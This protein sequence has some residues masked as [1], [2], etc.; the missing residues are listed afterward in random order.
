MITGKT[1]SQLDENTINALR[2]ALSISPDT[3]FKGLALT[4]TF[5]NTTEACYY[6]ANGPGTY[7]NF[8]G[9]TITGNYAF[10][11]WNGTTWSKYDTTIAFDLTDNDT[12]HAIIAKAIYED[13]LFNSIEDGRYF[14]NNDAVIDQATVVSSD[15]VQFK[16]AVR[17]TGADSNSRVPIMYA[18]FDKTSNNKGNYACAYLTPTESTSNMYYMQ[19]RFGYEFKPVS[20][21]QITD[22]DLF[23]VAI[24]KRTLSFDA[25]NVATITGANYI[26]K[27][28]K[29]VKINNIN[30][31]KVGIKYTGD[32]PSVSSFAYYVGFGFS[33]VKD[34]LQGYVSGLHFEQ[35]FVSITLSKQLVPFRQNNFRVKS[36]LDYDIN[37]YPNVWPDTVI[38]GL[39]S[40]DLY[41]R[42]TPVDYLPRFEIKTGYSFSVLDRLGSISITKTTEGDWPYWAQSGDPV[43]SIPYTFDNGVYFSDTNYTNAIIGSGAI[44][45]VYYGFW[46]NLAEYADTTKFLIGF[47]V[48]DAVVFTKPQLKAQGYSRNG[49]TIEVVN[50]NWVF[51]TGGLLTGFG[52]SGIP[53]T[54]TLKMYKPVVLYNRDGAT[55]INPFLTY[56]SISQKNNSGI[57]GKKIAV[58]G[59]SNQSYG[60]LMRTVAMQTGIKQHNG[61]A[62]G[63]KIAYPGQAANVAPFNS[64][65]Y[66][67]DCRDMFLATSM[68]AYILQISTNDI[69]NI[70][71]A[72]SE[73]KTKLVR[74]NYPCVWDDSSV[75]TIKM[76]GGTLSDGTVVAGFN[77]L[78]EQQKIDIFTTTACYCALIEQ[79]YWKNPYARIILC[80]IPVSYAGEVFD[81]S[82]R[83][84]LSPLSAAGIEDGIVGAAN[85]SKNLKEL[86]DNVQ[87]ISERYG[88]SFVDLYTRS[89]WSY[90]N[91]A[92]QT[93]NNLSD[94]THW[95]MPAKNRLGYVIAQELL[96]M[97]QDNGF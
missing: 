16:Q 22:T 84:W 53:N 74:D 73:T 76:S 34:G 21:N 49:I 12:Q 87:L 13:E 82:T 15:H 1:P 94:G 92:F 58:M 83:T 38:G 95:A 77:N 54:Q 46:L 68:Y 48:A 7:T 67:I 44:G 70:K 81:I 14:L 65:L 20:G 66:N 72:P 33:P 96:L 63:H 11:V 40:V 5:P 51:V 90:W 6:I 31:Y 24:D 39:S 60:A 41:N 25:Y 23:A 27:V 35:D 79:I 69:N 32:V 78:T 59:D 18:Y 30:S 28:Q 88:C 52:V 4:S 19:V 17:F 71:H 10:L 64:W 29:G 80:S 91:L 37:D 42:A 62:G 85:W 55:Q 86:R 93:Y 89:G 36:E 43:P 45:T 8:G 26:V 57:R 2:T 50:G 97:R 47:G 75:R 56:K 9:L 61:A 3:K